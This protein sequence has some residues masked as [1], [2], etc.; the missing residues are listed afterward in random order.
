[1]GKVFVPH[2]WAKT[3]LFVWISACL[4]LSP[5]FLWAKG[6]FFEQRENAYTA[7]RYHSLG[8]SPPILDDIGLLRTKVTVEAGVRKVKIRKVLADR[9]YEPSFFVDIDHF[10]QDRLGEGFYSGWQESR[11]DK[12]TSGQQ[13]DREFPSLEIEIPVKFPKAIGDLI[14]QGS[15]LK[16]TGSRRISIS[17]RSE[18]TEGLAVTSTFRPSKFPALNMEQRSRLRIEGTVGERIH[19][20]MDQDSERETNLESSIK[21]RYDGD[22]DRITQEI[23]A[24]NTMLSLPG[25]QFVGYSAQHKGL[26]GIRAKEK[27]GPLDL[28]IIASQEKGA[29]HRKTFRGLAKESSKEIRDYQYLRRIYFFFDSFYLNQFKNNRDQYGV[30]SFDPAYKIEDIDIYIDDNKSNNDIEMQAIPGRAIYLESATEG[31]ADSVRG[32]FHL[33]DPTEYFVDRNLGYVVL[34]SAVADE[35]VLAVA[36]RTANGTTHGDIDY[37][38]GETEDITLKLIKTRRQRSEDPS[39]Q[40]EW[41]N[42]YNL[43]TRDISPEGF[44]LKIYKDVAGAQPEDSQD[45]IPYLRIFGLDKHGE[46]LDSPPDGL[47]DLD[48]A[49][50][51][52]Q[53]GELIFPDLEPFNPS[54]AS[55]LKVKIPQIYQSR[56]QQTLKEA[57]RY[58]IEVKYRS[59]QTKFN[60]GQ[61][62]I[63]EGT[64]RVILNQKTLTRGVDYQINYYTGDITFYTDE[65]LNPAA[66]L[67]IDYEYKPF[68]MPQRKTLLGLRGERKFWGQSSA[69]MTLLYNSETAVE[70]RV[71]VGGEPTRTVLWDSNFD[72]R[73][74]PGVM[75]QAVNLL[76][77]VRTDATSSFNLTGEIAVNLPN[78]NTLGEAFI[79]DFEASVN[80][81]SL[82]I[83]RS[84]WTISSAPAG[85]DEDNR[86]RLIWYNPEKVPVQQ[87][88]PGRQVSARESEVHVLNL[89]FIPQRSRGYHLL[90]SAPRSDCWAGI[91]RALRG[92][93]KDFSRDKLLE[94]WVKGQQGILNIEL[95]SISED[96]IQNGQLDTEDRMRYGQR[97]GILDE[98][99]DTGLDGLFD[100]DEPGYDPQINPD[101]NGDDW[102][103]D[104]YK[105]RHN[106]SR[107]NGT[108]GNR[109]DGERQRPDTEDI[110]NNGYLD[111]DNDYY[112]YPVDL[113]TDGLVGGSPGQFLIQGTE[114]D[115][116]RLL[117][118]PLWRTGLHSKV[119]CPDSTQIEFVR[120]WVVGTDMETT[121]QIVSI[122]IVGNDWQELPVGPEEGLEI[123]VKNTQE[124]ADYT[125][126]PGVKEEKD[127]LTGVLRKEQALVLKF[128]EL[129]SGNQA[130]VYRTLFQ[131]QDYTNYEKM[132]V[133]VHGDQ[134]EADF[135]IR[136]GT[137][138]NNYYQVLTSTQSGWNDVNIDLVKITQLKG[139]GADSTRAAQMG[140]SLKGNPS[141]SS[142]NRF[143][144]GITNPG[145]APISGEIWVDELRLTQARN[146]RGIAGR[147]GVDAKFAD[148]LSLSG[149]YSKKDSE[150]HGLREKIGSGSDNI[151]QNLRADLKLD[152]LFPVGWGVSIPTGFSWQKTLSRPRL[153]P[154]SDVVLSDPDRERTQSE[155]RTL[156]V[157][158]RKQKTA[159]NPFVCWTLDRMSGNFSFN[160]QRGRSPQAPESS[161]WSYRG[162]F[163]YDLSPR[164]KKS[165]SILKRK[166]Y[167]LPTKFTFSATADNSGSRSQNQYGAWTRKH[168]FTLDQSWNLNWGLLEGFS[169]EYALKTKRDLRTNVDLS[170]SNLRLGE[171]S[172]RDQTISLNFRPGGPGWLRQDYSYQATYTEESCSR[173]QAAERRGRDAQV[174]GT[175]SARLTLQL[176]QLLNSLKMKGIGKKIQPLSGSYS[177][178]NSGKDFGLLRRP[179]LGYQLGISSKPRAESD[180][181]VSQRNSS[182]SSRKAEISTGIKL[183]SRLNLKAKCGYDYSVN[184][185]SSS[186]ISNRTLALPGVTLKWDGLQRLPFLNSLVKNSDL[187]FSYQREVHKK[188]APELRGEDL[189]SSSQK[190]KFSP[191]LGWVATWNNDLRSTLNFSTSSSSGTDFRNGRVSGTSNAKTSDLTLSFSYSLSAQRGIRLPFWG[192]LQLKSNLDLASTFALKNNYREIGLGL[193]PPMPQQ[194]ERTWSVSSKMSYQFSRKFTGG[195]KV[196]VSD[197]KD[198]LRNTTRKVRELGFWGEIRFD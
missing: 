144:L 155:R 107:I 161:N 177:H 47:I 48:E 133:F 88:W 113:S 186:S 74:T 35:Y 55:P 166:L 116:W 165:L 118:I 146:K 151:S 196:A 96:V 148:I 64:E 90:E 153:K 68:F 105:D 192:R 135:F 46:Q 84:L 130:A 125:S 56:D 169:W 92:G 117:Q 111:L 16:V 58:F 180:P 95:G 98:D 32:W 53:R 126:P 174:K 97:N 20:Q 21:I 3:I 109:A 24:G 181:S 17:G 8:F 167:Y 85:A 67:V 89:G 99:E 110:N 80:R 172:H 128:T 101:P 4:V 122:D 104:Y 139:G 69:G 10:M 138:E 51:N 119:G 13:R 147:L 42:V 29:T 94:I 23:E 14:G 36:Y 145:I 63:I 115:G 87:I 136:F 193:Q 123:M 175:L 12:R 77:L 52:R 150:F 163:S 160:E 49:I 61:F 179:H 75:T 81:V 11:R 19:I 22:E 140:Y 9:Q 194:D 103:Y 79:D 198:K 152:K 31:V 178:S 170:L 65:V 142:V 54:P 76:P 72:L 195:A 158:F 164:G 43:G 106:Y 102:N 189:L 183:L 191:L 60:L 129:G 100:Q 182:S 173:F 71:K 30:V 25:T 149:N 91:M 154:F 176:P 184:T 141:L 197:R 41:R 28:T 5:A 93:A 57:S 112:S 132:N 38:P 7:Y 15:S 50:I 159:A 78:Q 134:S 6:L 171:E 137:D 39:W 190:N 33:L 162:A 127:P 66:D 2:R 156:T 59:R 27:L 157:S 120:L 185:T 86:G 44:E 143:E 82:S 40:Y 83:L 18:W 73:F 26:F 131:K 187:N 1:M 62:G 121:I 70:K 168:N 188:G 108:E 114:S 37:R 34:N 45:G 124:N